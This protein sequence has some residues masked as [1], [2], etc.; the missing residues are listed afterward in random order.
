MVRRQPVTQ[1]EDTYSSSEEHIRAAQE[2]DGPTRLENESEYESEDSLE[3]DARLSVEREDAEQENDQGKLHQENSI[4]K[5][6]YLIDRAIRTQEF[7]RILAENTL[8]ET[9]AMIFAGQSFHTPQE[10]YQALNDAQSLGTTGWEKWT[11]GAIF[12]DDQILYKNSRG[13]GTLAWTSCID[14]NCTFHLEEKLKHEFFPNRLASWCLN[15]PYLA[16]EIGEVVVQYRD[17]QGYAIVTTD[18]RQYF[19]CLREQVDWDQC[20]NNYYMKHADQK[21]RAWRGL[22]QYH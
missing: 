1:A 11:P 19:A 22:Q 20:P 9:G 5:L 12:G 7:P 16:D 13:H 4:A 2:Y 21:C 15:K 17:P 8:E 18:P 3:E 14:R 10:L 6:R